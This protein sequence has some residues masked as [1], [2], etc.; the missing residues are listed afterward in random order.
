MLGGSTEAALLPLDCDV[1]GC[2][3]QPSVTA[4]W[5]SFW[6][7]EAQLHPALQAA[8]DFEGYFENVKAF[9]EVSA[10]QGF[11]QGSVA[12]L[13]GL[14][15][16]LIE[17]WA[18]DQAKGAMNRA[19][20]FTQNI[21]LTDGTTSGDPEFSVYSAA[22]GT[23]VHDLEGYVLV[24]SFATGQILN[25]TS[26]QE[27]F[28]PDN[29]T[30]AKTQNLAASVQTLDTASV[31]RWWVN[32]PSSTL[33]SVLVNPQMWDVVIVVAAVV[34]AASFVS[35]RRVGARIASGTNQ[36]YAY[37]LTGSMGRGILLG[38]VLFPLLALSY[39]SVAPSTG[40][41]LDP[42]VA[43]FG[44]LLVAAFAAGAVSRG[45]RRGAGAGYVGG[46]LGISLAALTGLKSTTIPSPSNSLVS[47]V[48]LVV[49]AGVLAIPGAFGGMIG[50]AV[51]RRRPRASRSPVRPSRSYPMAQPAG[52]P[53]RFCP[54]CGREFSPGTRF[55]RYCGSGV[56]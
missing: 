14:A 25:M 53:A 24:D 27:L 54:N 42:N 47:L 46:V 5:N 3:S 48:G 41:T 44:I 56:T 19:L 10:R 2:Q 43:Y 21:G 20:I 33:P 39:A 38:A 28:V 11:F 15:V 9:A 18:Y 12:G 40:S 50:G 52:K 8:V 30:Q 23:T 26:G 4:Y 1:S 13:A 32:P 35:S 55:C 29:Q 31:D 22:N 34:L 45:A 7:K 36:P 17:G 6:D 16:G 49:F 37:K 51:R